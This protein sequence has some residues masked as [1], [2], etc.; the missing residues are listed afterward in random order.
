MRN[1][2]TGRSWIGRAKSGIAVATGSVIAS[3]WSDAPA[4]PVPSHQTPPNRINRPV[5]NARPE[6]GRSSSGQY[7][8]TVT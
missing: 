1:G 2:R 4:R 3:R 8:P 5:N 7:K 6:P